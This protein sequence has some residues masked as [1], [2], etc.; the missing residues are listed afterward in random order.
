MGGVVSRSGSNWEYK[1]AAP[2]PEGTYTAQ[3]AQEDEAGNVGKSLGVT[4]VVDTTPPAVSI[5][6][7]ASPTKSTRPTLTG[8]AGA[9]VGD[10]EAVDVA[11]YEG[12]SASGTP[13]VSGSA[14]VTGSSWSYTPTTALHEATYTAQATQEDDAGNVGKSSAV[15]FTVLTKLPVVSMN[16][17]SSPTNDPTPTL[18]G[19]ASDGVVDGSTVSV[20]IYN[21]GSV[22]GSVAAAGVVSRSGANWEYTP[23]TPLP[24]GTYTAQATQED[25]AGA[26]G[27]SGAVTFVVDTTPP[28]VSIGAVASPTKNTRPTLTGGAGVAAGDEE[29]VEVAIYEG[30][31]VSGTPAVSGPATVAGSTWSYTPAKSLAEGIYTAE[32]FQE[33]EAGNVGES[34]PVTFTV[35]T[36]LP[37]VSIT[38]PTGGATLHVTQ[39]MFEGA[40]TDGVN[41][42]GSVRV[43]I[44]QGSSASGTPIEEVTQSEGGHWA[45]SWSY[46]LANGTYT[47]LATE[48]DAAGNKGESS[49]VTFKIKS[50]L[51]LE[52][53][54]F[55]NRVGPVWS[56]VRAQVS[57]G[58]PLK[59]ATR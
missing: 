20:T 24:E 21:G 25:E 17:V 57:R 16:A 35:L 10:D 26:V 28:S 37:V 59:P 45:L 56:Q 3:A 40:A 47:A 48:E 23:A 54:A 22:G 27:E 39:P 50:V 53:S 30:A 6:V 13:A 55:E 51:T 31:S 1:P 11:I 46:E 41:D 33:D 34:A 9:A 58:A 42:P 8:G 14:T 38:S 4:F 32:A 49:T 52:T 29:A 18:S 5:S 44:Y 2:L 7:V 36:R 19:A 15:T 43:K 12:T